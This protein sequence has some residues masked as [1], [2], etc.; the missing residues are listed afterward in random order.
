LRDSLW[1]L[2][3]CDG[4]APKNVGLSN[5]FRRGIRGVLTFEVFVAFAVCWRKRQD[6]AAWPGMKAFERLDCGDD[7]MGL[8]S[9]VAWIA[10]LTQETRK[11][12]PIEPVPAYP[13]AGEKFEFTVCENRHQPTSPAVGTTSALSGNTVFASTL[14][15]TRK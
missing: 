3:P 9:G 6:L 5:R 13:Q 2:T 11:L 1:I 4:L 8:V 7:G 15:S 12:V 10:I 14:S